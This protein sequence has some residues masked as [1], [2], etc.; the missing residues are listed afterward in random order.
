MSLNHESIKLLSI[1]FFIP[2]L[3]LNTLFKYLSKDLSNKAIINILYTRNPILRKYKLL[4][5]IFR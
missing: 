4:Y 3:G 5:N 2:S 1:I